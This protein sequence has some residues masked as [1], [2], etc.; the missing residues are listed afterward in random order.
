MSE[1]TSSVY[2]DPRN[3]QLT[4]ISRSEMFV[5]VDAGDRSAEV[6][7]VSMSHSWTLFT[8]PVYMNRLP[9]SVFLD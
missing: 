4:T 2:P 7:H 9:S 6:V 1:S 5:N 8:N 3:L